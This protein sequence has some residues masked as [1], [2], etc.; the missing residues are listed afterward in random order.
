[1]AG[2]RVGPAGASGPASWQEV[3]P[4]PALFAV[5]FLVVPVLELYVILR[6][7]SWIG[8]WPTVALLVLEGVLGA[9]IINREGRRAW[10]ALRDA[11]GTGRLPGRELAD[12]GLVL[13]GGTLLL[14]PGF[15]TD[16]AGFLLLLPMTRPLCRRVL[17]RLLMSRLF[18]TT[19]LG[20]GLRQ[21]RA[22]HDAG[23]GGQAPGQ[24]QVVRGEVIDRTD[25]RE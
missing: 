7:G 25:H 18:A 3:I 11:I 15:L 16:I 5:A 10:G 17:T 2:D 14:T 9:W 19:R 20:R 22:G 24:S 4:V 1:M 21:A 6:I 13:V 8:A 23:A 12:A